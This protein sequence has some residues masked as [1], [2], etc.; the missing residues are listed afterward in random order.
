ML[1]TLLDKA[2]NEA[3]AEKFEEQVRNIQKKM[4]RTENAFDVCVEDLFNKS[5]KL[6]KNAGNAEGDVSSLRSRLILP[7]EV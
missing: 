4:Q 6:K 1:L 2:A 5:L 3:E 7:G